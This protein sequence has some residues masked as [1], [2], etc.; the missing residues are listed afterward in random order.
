MKNIEQKEGIEN[1]LD[2]TLFGGKRG[3]N[4]DWIKGKIAGN[5]Q[6]GRKKT[7]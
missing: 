7:L 6:P 3:D 2:F 5:D 4:K 1:R